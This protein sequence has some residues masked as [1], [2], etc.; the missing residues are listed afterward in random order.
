M[1]RAIERLTGNLV[2]R[3]KLP[4]QF[5]RAIFYASP[6]AGLAY[7]FKSISDIDPPLLRLVDEVVKP[8]DVIWDV[9]AN[10]GLFAL[11]AAVR[12][13]EAGAVFAFEPDV[14]LVRLLRK[15][16][17]IQ[18]SSYAPMTV[19]PIAVASNIS[20][21]NFSI[22]SR[23]RAS[24]ALAE[25]GRSQMGSVAEQQI[26]PAFNLDWLLTHLPPPNVIKIDVEGAEA[27]I[28]RDQSRMLRSIRPV[29][30]C[31]VGAENSD[32]VTNILTAANYRIYDGQDSIRRNRT[33]D[34]ATWNTVA[35]PEENSLES[36]PAH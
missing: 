15:T 18:P 35:I 32:E 22:A 5:D 34:R 12:S 8:Q 21:R 17:R 31:E 23:A 11:C 16:S 3:R 10:L 26:V 27:E 36:S 28:L 25:Y 6:S 30:V 2:Y 7:L 33:V 1:R 19:I 20:L 9:G 14:W 29:I 13:G 24:N 4:A